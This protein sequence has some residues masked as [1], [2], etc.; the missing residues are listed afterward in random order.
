[1]LEQWI[2]AT[3]SFLYPSSL[4]CLPSVFLCSRNPD[5]LPLDSVPPHLFQERGMR[6]SPVPPSIFPLPV[7]LAEQAQGFQRAG[8]GVL[9]VLAALRQEIREQ[10]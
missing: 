5:T 8:A 6:L 2:S 7:L 3:L 10:K 1:M 9:E 4:I